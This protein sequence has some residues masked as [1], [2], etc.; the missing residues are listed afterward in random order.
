MNQIE[1][2]SLVCYDPESGVFTWAVD[3]STNALAGSPVYIE[4]HSGRT[5]CIRISKKRYLVSRLAWLYMYGTSPTNI[6][7]K[8]KDIQNNRI[9]NLTTTPFPTLKDSDDILDAIKYVR[10][11]P[12]TGEFFWNQDIDFER[13][14]GDF[15]QESIDP[16]GYK[17]VAILGKVYTCHRLA[18]A[19]TYK[20]IPNIIDHIDGNPSNNCINNLRNGTQRQNTRNKKMHREG[21]LIGAM[22]SG[23]LYKPWYSGVVVNKNL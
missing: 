1:L 12:T 7:H 15:L 19:C 13:R 9:E 6:Y 11:E 14:M 21:R 5:P 16:L 22:K 23:S 8:D 2:K 18:W 20:E 4:M 10:Y 17:S 3:R